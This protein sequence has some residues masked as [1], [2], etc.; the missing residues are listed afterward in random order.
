MYVYVYMRVLSCMIISVY[1]PN[2]CVYKQVIWYH[3]TL[4]YTADPVMSA[5]PSVSNFELKTSVLIDF[6][7]IK[8]DQN[9]IFKA[10]YR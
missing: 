4:L 10:H 8:V 9:R 2:R 6:S 7:K 1:S 3:S 5:A